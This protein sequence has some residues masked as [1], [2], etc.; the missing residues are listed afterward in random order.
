MNYRLINL[1]LVEQAVNL[2]LSGRSFVSL[3]LIPDLTDK[4]DKNLAI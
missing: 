4:S 1:L 3:L 2:E